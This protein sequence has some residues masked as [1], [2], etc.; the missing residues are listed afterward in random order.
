MA[1]CFREI[2][3]S[4]S[5]IV[6]PATEPSVVI[7]SDR[8]M[9]CPASGPRM[10]SRRADG[11]QP[12]NMHFVQAGSMAFLHWPQTRAPCFFLPPR[13]RTTSRITSSRT[14]PAMIPI[15]TGVLILVRRFEPEVGLAHHERVVVDELVLVDAALVHER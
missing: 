12:Q 2:A 9:V 6:L 7:S 3:G 10:N 4:A 14:P 5:T 11:C 8:R 13:A 1:T 15:R